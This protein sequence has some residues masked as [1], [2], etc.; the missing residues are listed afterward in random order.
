MCVLEKFTTTNARELKKSRSL[1]RLRY[2]QNAKLLGRNSPGMRGE[3][4]AD[5]LAKPYGLF[6]EMGIMVSNELKIRASFAK[7]VLIMRKLD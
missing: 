2:G 7:N 4:T 5:I 1:H 3:G 6:H